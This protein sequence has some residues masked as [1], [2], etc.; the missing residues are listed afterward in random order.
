MG[1]GVQ[2]PQ[3]KLMMSFMD[4]PLVE[5]PHCRLCDEEPEHFKHFPC[6]CNAVAR[7]RVNFVGNECLATSKLGNV[8]T[9]DIID[10]VGSF[11]IK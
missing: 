1:G 2:K 11:K 9:K 4:G 7:K 6:D 8:N 3:T 10:S 5:N